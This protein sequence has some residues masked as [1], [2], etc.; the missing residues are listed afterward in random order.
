MSVK[1]YLYERAEAERGLCILDGDGLALRPELAFYG[2]PFCQGSNRQPFA[3]GLGASALAYIYVCCADCDVV[4]PWPR[5][6]RKALTERINAPWLNR[7]LERTFEGTRYWPDYAPFPAHEFRGLAARKVL[8]V[9]PGPG[10]FLDYLRRIGADAVGVEP[11]AVAARQCE[12][13]GLRVIQEPFEESIL[14]RPEVAGEFDA[15]V[16]LESIYH[17]FD[18][19]E[20]FSLAHR[21]LRNGGQLV[22]KAFDVDSF[23]I[24]YFRAASAGIDGL[25]IPINA[26]ARTYAK[27]A[28]RCGFHVRRIY[29]CGGGFF[30]YLGLEWEAVGTARGRLGLRALERAGSL[31]LR[32]LGQSRNFVLFAEKR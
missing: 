19:R 9:G 5:L 6:T 30:S 29:P 12:K 7:Y 27:L 26:S 25:S 20:A 21:L 24:R 32:A 1:Q 22:I 11:N 2:C 16:F 31:I 8:E 23:P 13:R 28:G 3:S 17:L 18:L 4:Y 14:D 15:V 10:Q